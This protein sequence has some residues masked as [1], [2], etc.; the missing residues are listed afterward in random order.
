MCERCHNKGVFKPWKTWLGIGITI[1]ILVITQV[2]V[3][4]QFTQ[5]M[6]DHLKGDPS[7]KEMT[8]EFVTQK[9]FNMLVKSMD[10]K[11]EIITNFIK[12][13]N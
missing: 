4:G 2:F 11:L 1:L 5:S 10:E 12:E 8:Q 6:T 7:Y 3:Y 9:E 13:G